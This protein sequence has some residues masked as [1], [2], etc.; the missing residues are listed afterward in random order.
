M[1]GSRRAQWLIKEPGRLVREQPKRMKALFIALSTVLCGS[2][3][4]LGGSSTDRRP[5]TQPPTYRN[6]AQKA[7]RHVFERHEK[8][9]AYINNEIP[10]VSDDSVR[11]ATYNIHYHK[12]LYAANSN[13]ESVRR[14]LSNFNPTVVVFE[15][16]ESNVNHPNRKQFDQM[17]D[18]LGYKYREFYTAHA[19][20]GNMI[21]SKLP[22]TMIATEDLT[23]GRGILA[24]SFM[25]GD[26]K[27]AVLGT[28][29]EVQNGSIREQQTKQIVAFLKKHIIGKFDRYLLTGDMNASWTSPE[30]QTFRDS[31]LLNE[32]F[33][34]ARAP[35]PEY[36]CWAG[37]TI[38]FV[39]TSRTLSDELYGPYVYHTVSSD[40]LPVMVDIKV[41]KGSVNIP[42]GQSKPP[43]VTSQADTAKS[44][45]VFWGM[46]AGSIIVITVIVGGVAYHLH[47]K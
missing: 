5:Q 6:N 1:I 15:E 11:I 36:T 31:G 3:P 19:W 26:R 45:W 41:P 22:L 40:H 27:I 12:D 23:N 33:E 29:L 24:S 46:I 8:A 9:H 2:I 44:S 17:L 21:A 43:S 25:V 47:R 16:V 13:N 20:L 28:H 4:V 30:I 37:T 7:S 10:A 32:V 34:A 42:E 38:D 18:S 35:P 39:F 14:D